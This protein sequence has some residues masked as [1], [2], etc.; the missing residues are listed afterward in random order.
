MQAKHICLVVYQRELL[1]TFNN[2]NEDGTS[3]DDHFGQ[4]V[5]LSDSYAIISGHDEDDSANSRTETGK[6]YFYSLADGLLKHTISNPISD[7][8]AQS[9]KFSYSVAINEEYAVIGAPGDQFASFPG[10]V[11]IYSA[12]KVIAMANPIVSVLDNWKT[13][14]I[15]SQIE[16]PYF[17]TQ[18]DIDEGK[19]PYYDTDWARIS[20][21]ER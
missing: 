19:N 7:S 2:P 21:N 11:F 1:Y 8:T 17:L 18:Y 9:A 13:P 4:S 12:E 5:S 20:C 14:E 16:S 15:T 6:A 10:K 3:E